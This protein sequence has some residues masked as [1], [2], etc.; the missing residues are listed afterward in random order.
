MDDKKALQLGKKLLPAM[1]LLCESSEEAGTGI[2]AST[3]ENGSIMVTFCGSTHVI[4][5]KANEGKFRMERSSG[6][7]YSHLMSE[8]LEGEDENE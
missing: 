2:V 8:N 7:W 5:K 4:Q 3:C 6:S 1:K